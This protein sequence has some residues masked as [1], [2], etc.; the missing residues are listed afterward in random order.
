VLVCTRLDRVGPSTTLSSRSWTRSGN[1]TSHPGSWS[2][3]STQP[4]LKDAW[5]TAYW[6]HR[7]NTNEGLAAARARGRKGG[8]RPKL[9]PHQAELAQQIYDAREPTVQEIAELFTV[10]RSTIYGYLNKQTSAVAA[11]QGDELF[12]RRVLPGHH[13]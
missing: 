13:Q 4:P 7:V 11:D 2:K 9:N 5:S 1:A 8:R 3:A 6:P 10:P 12:F